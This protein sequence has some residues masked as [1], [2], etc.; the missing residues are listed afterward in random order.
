MEMKPVQRKDG[1]W[2]VRKQTNGVRITG[3]GKTPEEALEDF[4]I[5]S[6]PPVT[7]A[8]D[9]PLT[10]HEF[11]ES[12][13]WPRAKTKADL[14]FKRYTDAYRRHI[15]HQLGSYPIEAIR[16][17]DVQ[18]WADDHYRNGLSRESIKFARGILSAIFNLAMRHD[19][20]LRNPASKIELPG[21]AKPKRRRALSPEKA[22]EILAAVDGTDMAAPVFLA[23]VLGLRRG[24]VCG[25]KWD[26]I[27]RTTGRIHVFEQRRNGLKGQGVQ[28]DEPK[29]GSERTLM[30]P[31]K[32]I[33]MIDARGD[34]DSKQGYV[35]THN[36]KPWIP[37]TLTRLWSLK[38]DELKMGDW[39][40]HDLRHGAAGLLMAAGY[41]MEAIAL[42]LGHTDL[43][44]T[45]IY[46]DLEEE[47]QR[48]AM[49]LAVE[50]LGIR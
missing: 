18:A 9:G 44:T 8:S 28:T 35:C 27:E 17:T 13:W 31:T 4:R 5:K 26:S 7:T 10:L 40:Y 34:L 16:F 30:V 1:W 37:N 49:S 11:A 43:Q 25:L 46:T 39:H 50:R 14:T 3:L 41:R 15:K 32:I 48:T 22:A 33:E 36:G 29:R 21:K 2:I 6:Q 12:V 23:L 47:A 45:S 38:A 19:V 20:V 42:I 24:E